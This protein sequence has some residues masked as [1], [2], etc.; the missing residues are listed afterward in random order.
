MHRVYHFF[1]FF[2]IV[3]NVPVRAAAQDIFSAFPSLES[4]MK[5][6]LEAGMDREVILSRLIEYCNLND[7]EMVRGMEM[8]LAGDVDLKGGPNYA[9]RLLLYQ[10]N[11]KSY[12]PGDTI[13][14]ALALVNNRLYAAVDE[15]IRKEI[16]KDIV[17]HYGFY[18]KIVAWQKKFEMKVDLSHM[19]LI[20]KIYWADRRVYPPEGISYT[21][22]TPDDYREYTDTIETLEYFRDLADR[23][24]LY[25]GA[26]ITIIARAVN[27]FIHRKDEKGFKRNLYNPPLEKVRELIDR[28]PHDTGNDTVD[29]KRQFMYRGK[30][31]GINGFMW[32][33]YQRKLF[34]SL[35]HSIGMCE[36]TGLTEMILFKA[37]GI[38][39]GLMT[40]VAPKGCPLPGHVFAAYY[41]PI[42]KKWNNLE[43]VKKY[44]RPCGMELV[45]GKPLWHH[46]KD[47][48]KR[49][50]G[51]EPAPRFFR[52]LGLGIQ[53][54]H[55]DEIFFYNKTEQTDAI[56]SRAALPDDLKD[57]DGDTMYDFEK[58]LLG[59]NPERADTADDGVSDL[60]KLER[61]LDPKRPLPDQE[62]P[63]VDGLGGGYADS[64]KLLSINYDPYNRKKD[65]DEIQDIKTLSAGR[66]GDAVYISA[67]FHSDINRNKKRG[68]NLTLLLQGGRG[69]YDS[70]ELT[71]G[72]SNARPASKKASSKSPDG[73]REIRG[74]VI[75]DLELMVPVKY[76]DGAGAVMIRYS[77]FVRKN[78]KKVDSIKPGELTLPI[79]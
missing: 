63:P 77:G 30:R 3:L 59:L 45:I 41:D 46:A 62:I 76:L 73:F 78:G 21:V 43:M 40:R 24:R 66:F 64:K 71:I 47:L 55:F 75:K 1:L 60:W 11:E 56:F 68:H 12:V 39:S 4:Q 28:I 79:R 36:V 37:M 32:I 44:T 17:R 29:E 18:R 10:L 23:H 7:P 69:N 20:P 13:A 72:G 61:G 6:N 51:T 52:L 74:R 57:S 31:N 53:E 9:L 65:F 35:G 67:S 14:L 50:R 27:D 34:E 5:V 8:I 16:R 38:P 54:K 25:D 22:K 49:A 33:N 58:K 19:P 2:I 48:R 42:R 15:T 26:N 70:I